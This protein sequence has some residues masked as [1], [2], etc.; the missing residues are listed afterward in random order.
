MIIKENKQLNSSAERRLISYFN[1]TQQHLSN[2]F[3]S[4][5]KHHTHFGFGIILIYHAVIAAESSQI[6]GTQ[7][8]TPGTSHLL[9]APQ[10]L[11]VIFICS[12]HTAAAVG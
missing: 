2:S 11:G 4:S 1:T 10:E 9:Q 8:C 3:C 6:C 5:V 12:T 7:S